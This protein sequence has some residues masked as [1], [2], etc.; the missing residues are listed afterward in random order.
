MFCFA[1][2]NNIIFGLR[3]YNCGI[4]L[5]KKPHFEHTFGWQEL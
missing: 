3:K 5:K 1:E 4:G 2:D